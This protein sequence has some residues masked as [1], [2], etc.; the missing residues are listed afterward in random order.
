MDE[1]PYKD[2]L[3]KKRGEILGTGAAGLDGNQHPSG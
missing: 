2:A 1:Q 3:L